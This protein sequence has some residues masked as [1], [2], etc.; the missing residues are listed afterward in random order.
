MRLTD[1]P[2]HVL[3]SIISLLGPKD[4]CAL[5]LTCHGLH[6]VARSE[7]L[8]K[9]FYLEEWECKSPRVAVR[10]DIFIHQGLWRRAFLSRKSQQCTV[11]DRDEA[12]Y[13]PDEGML[14]DACTWHATQFCLE[15]D[16]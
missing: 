9:C 1:L 6:H 10:W 11:C 4:A 13:M 14:C 7:S 15:Y 12:S 16:V 8:W 2:E 3:E 5:S